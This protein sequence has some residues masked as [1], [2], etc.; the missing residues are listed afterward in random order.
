MDG[1]WRDDTARN[2]GGGEMTPKGIM[3]YFSTGLVVTALVISYWR[4]NGRSRKR[5]ELYWAAFGP[6]IWPIVIIVHLFRVFED[7]LK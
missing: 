4:P 1:D 5:S 7:I 6:F 3:A 2:Q